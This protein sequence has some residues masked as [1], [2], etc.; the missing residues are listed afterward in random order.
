M[1]R[2]RRSGFALGLAS[3]AL[4]TLYSLRR[5][6][7]VLLWYIGFPL[8][9]LV[10]AKYIFLG[11]GG[12]PAI[13]VY[14]RD[15][16]VYD[17]LESMGLS[18][19]AAESPEELVERLRSGFIAV[20]ILEEEGGVRVLYS[21]DEYAPLARGLA[22]AVAA[23]I[24]GGEV[25]LEGEDLRTLENLLLRAAGV[26]VERISG[27]S[28]PE[29]ALAE[30]SVNLVGVESL[31]IAL[32]GGMVM[33]IAMRRE[34]MLDLVASSPGGSRS[35]LGFMTGMNLTSSIV[36]TLAI[37]AGSILLGADYS[38]VNP[39]G[40]VAGAVLILAGLETIFLA[41]IPIS[42]LVK[43]EETAA[44]LAGIA[45]FLLIFSTGLAIPREMLPGLLADVS[46]YFP[47]TL[48]VELGKQ[49]IFGSA[50]P[51]EALAGAWPL[52]ITL[53]LAGIVGVLSYRRVMALA[54][55]E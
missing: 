36:T 11:G 7:S 16:R 33:L 5:T 1:S 24:L 4:M 2:G 13:G 55:E 28:G 12:G 8:L 40:V 18:P 17:I 20:A 34:R 42:L 31:Y 49:A 22:Q 21:S 23:S 46:L 54:V 38:G 6:P 9:L 35:L 19:E 25:G 27:D 32:Y 10:I 43:T 3:G 29:R 52:Y 50:T 39:L 51:A 14:P 37:L 47:L 30:Y 48:A 41:S 44:A 26:E 45:G 53:A 15:S